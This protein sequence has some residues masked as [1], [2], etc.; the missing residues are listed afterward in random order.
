MLLD[1]SY[2][3]LLVSLAYIQ[4]QNCGH[5][6]LAVDLRLEKL[7]IGR[8]GFDSRL[9]WTLKVYNCSPLICMVTKYK[10]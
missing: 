4:L 6:K 1:L 2:E 9:G 3:V 7:V 8:P 10:K 5:L